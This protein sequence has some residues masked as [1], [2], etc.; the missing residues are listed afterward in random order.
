MANA[1]A[2]QMADRLEAVAE[3]MGD[4]VKDTL[5]WDGEPYDALVAEESVGASLAPEGFHAEREI[6]ALIR[7]DLF[8]NTRPKLGDAMGRESNSGK[9]QVADMQRVPGAFIVLSLT[10]AARKEA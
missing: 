9:Y 4:L 5:F 10:N 7:D 3:Q 1:L 6:R 2:E 8:L